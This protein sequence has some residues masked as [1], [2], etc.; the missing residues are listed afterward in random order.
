MEIYYEID[1]PDSSTRSVRDK[2]VAEFYFHQGYFVNEVKLAT[3]YHNHSVVRTIVTT[4]IVDDSY[5][6]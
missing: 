1:D 2:E 3:I 4:P 6:Q 5:F